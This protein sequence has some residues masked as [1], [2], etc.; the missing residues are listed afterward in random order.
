MKFTITHRNESVNARTGIIETARG[1]IE[2]PVFMPVGTQ[3]TVKALSPEDLKDAGAQIILSNT[4]HLYLRPG[5]ETVEKLGGLHRFM[6]W[7]RPIL[8]DSGGYQVYSLAKLRKISE[9]GVTFQSHIDGSRHFLGPRESMAIQKALGSDIVMAFDECAPYPADYEYV[10]NSVNLTGKWARVCLDQGLCEGQNLFGIVQ[11][12]MYSDLREKSAKE[13]VAMDFP[14]YALGGLSVGEDNTTRE[15]VISQT[16]KFLPENKPRYLMG[17]G[18]PEDILEAVI[19]GVDMFDCVMPTRNARNGSLFV[20]SGRIVI[21]NAAY[22]EDSSP[23]DENCG[24]Y[25]CRN[26][27]RAYLRHLFMANE[28]LAYRLNSIHNIYYYIRFMDRIKNA[29]KDNKLLEFQKEFY[30]LRSQHNKGLEE[31]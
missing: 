23:I 31:S 1:K 24:C 25:T 21:K 7:D 17:V 10:N 11:G 30:K 12:G 28:L 27:S 22:S 26:Y 8:T 6:N 16:V 20:D 3:G 2:T 15:R 4:Y 5:H 9:D 18:K 29:I 19:L 14:G 13:L